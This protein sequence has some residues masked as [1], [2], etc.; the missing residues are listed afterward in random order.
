METIERAIAATIGDPDNVPALLA[1]ADT[2]DEVRA[3]I[4]RTAAA[5][6]RDILFG[7]EPR[8]FS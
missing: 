7:H 8:G 4:Q 6:P 1:N 2:E 3:F 5:V